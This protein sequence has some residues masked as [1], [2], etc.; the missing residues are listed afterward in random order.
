L[1]EMDVNLLCKYLNQIPKFGIKYSVYHH[2]QTDG[3]YVRD[4]T[5]FGLDFALMNNI[6]INAIPNI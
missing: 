3:Y 1:L 5:S 4:G 2:F 6:L